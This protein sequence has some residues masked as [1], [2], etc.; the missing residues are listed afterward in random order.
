[1]FL[2]NVLGR[3]YRLPKS[4]FRCVGFEPMDGV[5]PWFHLAEFYLHGDFREANFLACIL[6][7]FRALVEMDLLSV[8]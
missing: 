6:L 1:M 5:V 7:H 2:K 3:R 8:P 4:V